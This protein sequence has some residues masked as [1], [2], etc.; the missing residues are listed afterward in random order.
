MGLGDVTKTCNKIQ[1]QAK[2]KKCKGNGQQSP[3]VMT[4]ASGEIRVS[5]KSERAEGAGMI[6][7]QSYIQ[8]FRP[9]LVYKSGKGF[10]AL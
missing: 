6:N 3:H 2:E 8:A 7:G 1:Q 5:L 4:V 9:G 10:S